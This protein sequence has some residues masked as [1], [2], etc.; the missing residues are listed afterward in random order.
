MSRRRRDGAAAP[1]GHCATGP[2]PACTPAGAG[3][4]AAQIVRQHWLDYVALMRERGMEVPPEQAAAA[5]DMRDCRTAALGS[6]MLACASCGHRQVVYHSCHHRLCPQ[7]GGREAGE[8][9]ARQRARQLPVPYFLVT[10]TVPKPMRK[11]IRRHPRLGLNLMFEHSAGALQQVAGDARHLHGELGMISVLHTW[12]R[13]LGFHPHI[14]VLLPGVGLEAIKGRCHQS[15]KE[16]YLAPVARLSACWR[17]RMEEALRAHLPGEHARLTRAMWRSG[18]VTHVQPAGTGTEALMYIARY[19][20][21]SALGAQQLL[22][23]NAGGVTFRWKDRQ[24]GQTRLSTLAPAL[25]LQRL[26]QH[27]LPKGFRRVRTYGWLSPAAKK[28]FAAVQSMSGSAASAALPPARTTCIQDKASDP[29][30]QCRRCRAP[31]S[32]VVQQPRQSRRLRPPLLIIATP[33]IIRPGPSADAPHIRTPICKNDQPRPPP[34][35]ILC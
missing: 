9:L 21:R 19:I 15:K 17:A 4:L 23:F 1:L 5:Q 32:V 11:V 25:F 12:R 24:S 34:A 16:D 35:T 22:T 27:T 13:D 26:L 14:H 10:F 7:C 30:R 3:G 29:L 2:P 8:W 28:R 6:Q 31:V 33:A 18:W 20:N